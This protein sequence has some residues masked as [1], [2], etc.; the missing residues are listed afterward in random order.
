MNELKL[1]VCGMKHPENIRE[2]AEL[3]PDYMGFIFYEKTP[4]FFDAEIPE[5]PK[6]IKKTGVFVD[7]DAAFILEKIKEHNLNAVQLHGKESAEFCEKLKESINENGIEIIKVFSV[8]DDFVFDKLKKY[9]GLVDFFLFDTKGKNKGGNGVSFNWEILKGYPSTTP[10]FLSGGIGLEEAEEI[11]KLSDFFRKK[12]KEK[13]LYAVDVNSRF[14]SE[15]GLKEIE[16]L[17]IFKNIM[18]S[19]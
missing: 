19:Y 18:E 13:L 5:I 9:E 2:V 6:S 15:P 16:K 14:E 11:K 12:G 10:F 3:V 4:R 17:K 7:A 8:K 1:K